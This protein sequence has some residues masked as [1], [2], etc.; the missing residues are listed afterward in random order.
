[1]V[2]MK[3]VNVWQYTCNV[4]AKIEDLFAVIGASL[5]GV[6]MLAVVA[7]STSRYL[8]NLSLPA[9]I[10]IVELSMPAVVF[11]AMAYTQRAGRQ[12]RVDIILER[13][14]RQKRRFFEIGISIILVIICGFLTYTSGQYAIKAYTFH[15]V[16]TNAYIIN[17]PSKVIISV[18]FALL[19]V[20]C[21]L[22]IVKYFTY[23]IQSTK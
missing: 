2:L 10:E 21:I 18:A 22:Q 4:I 15:D 14:Q 23:N 12:I 9:H 6:I 3:L 5:I 1:M 8:F 11:L 19:T 16:T 13:M 7:E 20:R 17:W